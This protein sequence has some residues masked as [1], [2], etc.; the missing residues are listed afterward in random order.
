MD[1]GIGMRRAR[2][3]ANRQ[4]SIMK[5]VSSDA[6]AGVQTDDLENKAC[7]QRRGDN[8]ELCRYRLLCKLNQVSTSVKRLWRL[9]SVPFASRCEVQVLPV[10]MILP[11]FLYMFSFQ[12]RQA[13]V[14]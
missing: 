5:V 10:A 8:R 4:K 9:A 11:S 12:K 3:V 7:N 1:C 14:C 2:G 6:R 13:M